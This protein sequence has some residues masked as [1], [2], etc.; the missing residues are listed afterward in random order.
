MCRFLF[1]PR[2]PGVHEKDAASETYNI[3]SVN[4]KII[5]EVV[6]KGYHECSF[7]VSIGEKYFVRRKRG[8][9]RTSSEGT[10]W[11]GP[12]SA[13][14]ITKTMQTGVCALALDR[15]VRL[16]SEIELTKKFLFDYVW[17]QNQSKNNQTIGVWLSSTDS[18]FQLFDWLHLGLTIQKFC[19][20]DV[21][22]KC[23]S[24]PLQFLSKAWYNATLG[25][26]VSRKTFSFKLTHGT[27]QNIILP[28]F[29]TSCMEHCL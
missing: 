3:V 19:I 4:C 2:T 6:V 5:F 8:R 18:S 20:D 17:L 11:K 9:L 12:K 16:S 1:Q 21:D 25:S 13:R 10:R 7:A 24:A 27:R 22:L 29:K 23:G 26:I 14:A 28:K 15:L